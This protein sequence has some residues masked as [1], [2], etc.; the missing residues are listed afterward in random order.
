ML[1][2]NLLKLL[3]NDCKGCRL[4]QNGTRQLQTPTTIGHPR[5]VMVHHKNTLVAVDRWRTFLLAIEL[6][7]KNLL[8]HED[9][10]CNNPEPQSPKAPD[11]ESAPSRGRL[12]CC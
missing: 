11:E 4:I 8:F 2:F 3:D 1:S 12:C 10:V 5:A 6:S 7:N 9:K